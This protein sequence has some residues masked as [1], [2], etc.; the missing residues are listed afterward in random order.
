MRIIRWPGILALAI[1][2]L[3]MAPLVINGQMPPASASP[4]PVPTLAPPPDG[5]GGPRLSAIAYPPGWNIVAV[6]QQGD[7]VPSRSPLYT[8]QADDMAYQPLPAYSP[9]Q[10]GEG[11]RAY[12]DEAV[13]QYLVPR[14]ACVPLPN[15]QC[16]SAPQPLILLPAGQFIMIGNPFSDVARVTGADIV[17]VYDPVSGGYQQST[18][19]QP[20]Q[21][22]FAYS[23]AG[24]VATFGTSGP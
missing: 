14:P 10:V 3:S 12:F 22:A 15:G 17:Y 13:P 23:A 19:L 8:L 16:G 18:V 6:T 20:G 21:G 7:S 11:Y 2:T 24:G 4:T 9:L 5:T 1:L